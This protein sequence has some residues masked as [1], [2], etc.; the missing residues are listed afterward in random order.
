[1]TSLVGVD[2]S[3]WGGGA[4]TPDLCV[5]LWVVNVKV[6]KS[7]TLKQ[8][9][10]SANPGTYTTQPITQNKETPPKREE[11]VHSERAPSDLVYCTA[12]VY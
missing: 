9:L 6:L 12:I 2:G 10:I 1:M 7:K 11:L 3:L 8:P 4:L 5:Q